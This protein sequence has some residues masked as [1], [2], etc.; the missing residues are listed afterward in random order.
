M[1]D[2]LTIE[3]ADRYH[4]DRGPVS[5]SAL[6][7]FARSPAHYRA[8]A[9]GE[10]PDE[11]TPAMRLGSAVHCAVL[12]PNEWGVRYVV[13]P[14]DVDRRNKEGK[15][16]AAAQGDREILTADQGEVVWGIR[17]AV[18]RHPLASALLLRTPGVNERVARWTDKATG[19]A[20]KARMDRVCIHDLGLGPEPVIVDLK[21]ASDAS[22]DGFRRTL[23]NNNGRQCVHYQSALEAL[24]IAAAAPFLWVVTETAAP[25]SV[26][27][28]A[29]PARARMAMVDQYRRE[30]QRLAVCLAANDWP[31]YTPDDQP[32][33]ID[34]PPWW[35]RQTEEGD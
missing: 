8:W 6:A 33:E 29:M 10:I 2:A 31:G 34:L 1:F 22:P 7:R 4:A 20:C 17:R 19:L 32:M 16:W 12:E 11:P 35:Y 27:V 23:G 5:A 15:A 26:A 21:T 30:L 9:D 3:P 24:G 13:Q 25:F 18:E 28:Y 14:A